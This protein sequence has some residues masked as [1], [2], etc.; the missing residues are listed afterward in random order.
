M[1][2]F[3]FGI[4]EVGAQISPSDCLMFG[5][6]FALKSLKH[7]A[8]FEEMHRNLD[9]GLGL[10]QDIDLDTHLENSRGWLHKKGRMKLEGD[11]GNMSY[12][13]GALTLPPE[14]F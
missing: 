13:L 6:N 9:N 4:I 8:I 2:P 14:F 1:D 7:E 5:L 3:R 11:L 10:K 12:A